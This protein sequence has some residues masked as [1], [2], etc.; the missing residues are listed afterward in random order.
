MHDI[1]ASRQILYKRDLA[2][3]YDVITP[4]LPPCI[5]KKV[6]LPLYPLNAIALSI[7]IS[8]GY[9]DMGGKQFPILRNDNVYQLHS[10]RET[11]R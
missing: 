9:C 1:Q 10:F 5:F 7:F 2:R 6:F 11:R 3:S 8:S 4:S